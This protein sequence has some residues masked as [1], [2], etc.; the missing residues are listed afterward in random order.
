MNLSEI[1]IKRPVFPLIIAIAMCLFGIV[2]LG[3]MPLQLTPTVDL[4]FVMITTVYPGADADTIESEVTEKIEDA[5][6]VV[7]DIKTLKSISLDNVSLVM[8]EFESDVDAD[9]KAQNFREKIATIRRDLPDNIDEPVVEKFD[10]NA[11]PIVAVIVS[12]PGRLAKVTQFAEDVVKTRLQQI[13]DVGSVWRIGGRERRIRIW[14]DPMKLKAKKYWMNW[15][16]EQS[17]W[18]PNTTELK[19]MSSR[20]QWQDSLSSPS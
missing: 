19:N 4:P 15:P 6:S 11:M 3:S 8:V 12:G 9:V 14:L 7:S 13:T 10:I 5:I 1:S 2:A 20:R 16:A 17:S 18:I